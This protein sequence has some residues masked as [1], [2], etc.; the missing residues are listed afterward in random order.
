MNG[1]RTLLQA[2]LAGR[3]SKNPQYSLR[4]FAR[5]LETDHSTLS[6]YLRGK[7]R[8]TG[9][10]IRKFG[11]RL[12]LDEEAIERYRVTEEHLAR[13]E[14]QS[15]VHQVKELAQ[16]TASLIADWHHYAILE[17]VRLRDFRPDTRWIARVLGITPDEVNVALQRLLR[18]RLL[19]MTAPNQWVDRSGDTEASLRG[20]AQVAIERLLEQVRRLTATAI[21]R[22]PEK[23]Y[24]Y[25]ATT[26]AVDTA[27]VS[28]AIAMIGRMRN[29]LL[30]L[31]DQGGSRNDVYHLEI[32]FVPATQ[33]QRKETDT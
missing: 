26:V 9:R 10:A 25:S 22:L 6:Q 16:D 32:A 27:R 11:A 19:E 31:L 23:A 7:R 4:A 3:C 14:D 1:L 18:L 12:G 29:Q 2:E 33:L 17:L 5:Y 28:T 21:Q 20:F 8:L 15:I 30:A 13:D 24:A